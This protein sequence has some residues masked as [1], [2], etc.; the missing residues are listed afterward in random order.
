MRHQ[1]TSPSTEYAETELID[2]LKA[3]QKDAFQYLVS[4]HHRIMLS[5]AKTIVGPAY[6]DEVVQDSWEKCLSAIQSFEGRS[7]IRTWLLT[8]VS[9]HAKTRIQRE[10]RQSSLD[11]GWES[12]DNDN[13]ENSRWREGQPGM[14]HEDTPEA[15]LANQQLTELIQ[16][17]LHNLPQKQRLVLTLRDFEDLSFEEI[18]DVLDMNVNNV[19]TSLHRARLSLRSTISDYQTEGVNQSEPAV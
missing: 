14:W 2:A 5:V 10:Q 15:I 1:S 6:A 18:A 17:R 16:Q 11:E 4:K 9:N 13:F 7:K 19:R 12:A 3:G 8:I